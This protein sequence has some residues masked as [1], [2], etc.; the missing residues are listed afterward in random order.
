MMITTI[1]KKSKYS[2][3]WCKWCASGDIEQ[4]IV[5][6]LV[7]KLINVHGIDDFLQKYLMMSS[8]I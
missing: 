5:K 1:S 2:R 7:F 4:V 3:R 6:T 8:S